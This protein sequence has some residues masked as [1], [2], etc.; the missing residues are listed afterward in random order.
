MVGAGE[1]L[2]LQLGDQAFQPVLNRDCVAAEGGAMG[3]VE[4]PVFGERVL[5]VRRSRGRRATSGG[6]GWRRGGAPDAV[7]G[8]LGGQAK[9]S[10]A[11]GR[12]AGNAL[13]RR[14][15]RILSL[16]QERDQQLQCDLSCRVSYR[17]VGAADV[18]DALLKKAEGGNGCHLGAERSFSIEGLE[19]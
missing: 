16:C 1:A 12:D 5:G 14:E 15:L 17:G 6:L 13:V 19:V 10:V 2:A 4:R 8:A 11:R 18:H 7:E 3:A 9:S